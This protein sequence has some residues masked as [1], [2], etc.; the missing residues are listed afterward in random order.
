[1]CKQGKHERKAWWRGVWLI[2][3]REVRDQV[4]DWRIVAPI[5]G[6]TLFFPLLMNLT[7]DAVVR[8]VTKYGADIVAERMFPFLMMIVGFFPSSISLVVALESFVGERERR[9]IEPLLVSPLSD[10]QLYL[11][12]LLA[13][14]FLPLTVSYFGVGVYVLGMYFTVGWLPSAMLITMVVLLTTVQAIMMVSAAV[15]ISTQATSVRSANLLAS[16]I[17]VPVAL[18]LQGESVLMF[19]QR[20]GILWEVV[21]AVLVVAVL[22]SRMGLAH[23]NRETLLGREMDV[24]NTRWMRKVF[25]EAFRGG[26]GSLRAWYGLVWQD[27]KALW[28]PALVSVVLMALAAGVGAWLV[29]RLPLGLAHRTLTVDDLRRSL[30]GSVLGVPLGDWRGTVAVWWHNVRALLLA[31]VGAAFSFGVLGVLVPLLPY[32]ILG[33]A[34]AFMARAGVFSPWTAFAVMVLPHG[35]AELPATALFIAAT[36]QLGAS[37]ASPAPGETLGAFWLRAWARWW[38]VFLGVVVPLM[39]VAAVLET[40]LTPWVVMRFLL[41]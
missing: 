22:I 29:S 39:G 25:W 41:R 34:F 21:A 23:F 35:I 1:M 19:W 30:Q 17:I 11:G 15:V 31:T 32:A 4:R 37:L 40:K 38:R 2:A 8:F 12:K 3:R 18:M 9:T 7:A 24:L 14:L 36:M 6:L 27:V 5:V 28:K 33:G 16:L 10:G 26:A 13:V 20:Y